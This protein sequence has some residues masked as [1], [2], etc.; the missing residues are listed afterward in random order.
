MLRKCMEKRKSGAKFDFKINRDRKTG[1][2]KQRKHR[3]AE[4]TAFV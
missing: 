3:F 1:S 4:P 2:A